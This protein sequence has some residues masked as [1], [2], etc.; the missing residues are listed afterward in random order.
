MQVALELSKKQAGSLIIID[1]DSGHVEIPEKPLSES[2]R[3]EDA[4]K[5]VGG[6]DNVDYLANMPTTVNYPQSDNISPYFLFSLTQG[7]L[8]GITLIY[9]FTTNTYQ[10]SKSSLA[11][12]KMQI[13][14][15]MIR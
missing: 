7:N 3:N 9:P 5:P 14:S 13:I 6:K 4:E 15:Q 2:E 1:D 12:V 10:R 11:A 8:S